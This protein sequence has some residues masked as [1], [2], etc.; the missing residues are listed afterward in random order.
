MTLRVP[1]L[2]LIYF[3]HYLKCFLVDVG[4]VKLD[5]N[6]KFC[7]LKYPSADINVIENDK[8]AYYSV[9][10]LWRPTTP[11]LSRLYG[12]YF[13]KCHL[14]HADRLKCRPKWLFGGKRKNSKSRLF[15]FAAPKGFDGRTRR[16]DS[17]GSSPP[18]SI[19][20]SLVLQVSVWVHLKRINIAYGAAV[21]SPRRWASH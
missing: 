4:Y 18:R 1:L 14:R 2:V 16:H 8:G 12:K 5:T 21:E 3:Y 15:G 6:R 10:K 7:G 11:G 9:F 13:L 20:K 19:K 17:S